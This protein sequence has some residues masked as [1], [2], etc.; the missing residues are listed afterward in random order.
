MKNIIAPKWEN[1][2]VTAEKVFQNDS[3]SIKSQQNALGEHNEMFFCF[4]MI[5]EPNFLKFS[6]PKYICSKK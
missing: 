3:F 5:G 2:E 4:E 1:S 6:D